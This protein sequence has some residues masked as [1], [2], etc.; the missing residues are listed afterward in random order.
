M[1]TLP[2]L[3][4]DDGLPGYSANCFPV[5]GLI[6]QAEEGEDLILSFS[7]KYVLRV[8]VVLRISMII[9]PTKL[10]VTGRFGPES[11]LSFFLSILSRSNFDHHLRC[12]GWLNFEFS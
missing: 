8:R 3:K 12:G 1:A 7:K 2:G 4:L 5:R 9:I 6:R 11:F 10:M